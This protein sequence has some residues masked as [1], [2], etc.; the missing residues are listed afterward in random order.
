M[1][2]GD[3]IVV[4]NKGAVQMADTPENVYHHPRNIFVAKFIGSPPMN[5]LSGIIRDSRFHYEDQNIDISEA[6]TISDDLNN[7]EV[8]LGI[9]PEN[10]ELATDEDYAIKCKS[11][12]TENFG[13]ELARPIKI[14]AAIFV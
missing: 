10:M 5:T 7:T 1:A 9:R 4:L 2:L 12:L 11:I 14:A 13:A 8:Y 6:S 3:R